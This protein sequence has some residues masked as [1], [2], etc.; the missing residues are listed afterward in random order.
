MRKIDPDL[1]AKLDGGATT[2][3]RCWR[4]TRRD[5]RV[6]GFTDHDNDLSFDG[7]S[8]RASS[9]LNATAVQATT[10]F[11][12]DNAQ[13]VGALSDAGISDADVTAGRF[14]RA[15]VEHWLVDWTRPVLSILLFVGHF[16]EI[17]RADGAFEVELR[18]LTETLNVTVGRTMH[19]GC[20][21]RLGDGKCG[22]D[23]TK[24]GY[25][26]E[27]E[28]VSL[29]SGSRFLASGLSAFASGWF[30]AGTLTWVSAENAPDVSMVKLDAP[31]DGGL[32]RIEIWTEPGFPIRVGDRFRIAAGCDK[33]LETC[34]DKFSNLPNFR[35]FP[36]IPGDDW[37]AAYPK[38]G[39][40]NDGSSR[41]RR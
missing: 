31:G 40:V 18:G 20:D 9:G 27:A 4:V 5:G 3:C 36:H 30:G 1:R 35:G 14:D 8:F 11:A 34:R 21:R 28:V 38:N 17:R 41:Q 12:V 15:D 32:R 22:F 23:L 10:G 13:A 7:T 25:V 6:F 37:V 26:G 19:R 29:L 24:A 2:L 33:R 39:D 16:G